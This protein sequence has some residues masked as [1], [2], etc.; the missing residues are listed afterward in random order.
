MKITYIFPITLFLLLLLFYIE[1][2]DIRF[3]PLPDG[4]NCPKRLDRKDAL[5]M[6]TIAVIYGVVAF[7]GLGNTS[8]PQ[9]FVNMQGASASFRLDGENFPSRIMYFCGVGE[10][11][12]TLEFS[13]D[14]NV[15]H[16]AGE[17]EQDYQADLK[18]KEFSPQYSDVPRFMRVTGNGAVWFGEIALYGDDGE[19]MELIPANDGASSMLCDEQDTA[20]VK[21]DFH[22]SSYFDEIYHARTAWEHLNSVQPYEVSHPPLGKLIIALGIKLFGMTPF[23]WRFSGTFFGVLMLPIMYIFVKKMF[24]GRTAPTACTVVLASDF[25]HFVQTRIATIDTYGV[26][27]ILLMY[28][29][30]YLFIT[31]NDKGESKKAL[32]FL[33]LSGVS[34]GLGAASKWTG[35]YAGAGLAVIWLGYWA[36]YCKDGV[37]AFIKNA[38]FCVV[39]FVIIPAA[40]YYVSYFAYGRA[41]GMSGIGMFFKKEYA[42]MVLG[43]QQL[44]FSYHSGL[45]AEHPYSSK[46]YQWIL[47]IR[48]I[49]YYLDDFNDGTRSSFGAFVNPV[50]CWG[51]LVAIAVLV[52]IAVSRRERNALF[53]VLAYLAQLLP[54][55]FVPRLTFAYHYFPCS[56]FLVMALGYIFKLV[57]QNEKWKLTVGGFCAVSVLTFVLFYPALTGKIVDSS[58]ATKLLGWLPTWPF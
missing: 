11:C 42:H 29:F 8:S 5:I 45:V 9:T 31:E 54:W 4:K 57:R 17:L 43:N 50:L 22:N 14:G 1:L 41:Y 36:F 15:W 39:F 52:F 56:V 30:M 3:C 16:K 46:W 34:F 44:M 38:L 21:S 35:L 33:A 58:T 12:Y 25:M 13:Q 23:G 24:G 55:V 6:A 40:I 10:G 20:V 28:L 19:L 47:D 27:F 53:I 26:F 18:W 2:P 7:T 37:K 49:L 48:P 51:G 32:C